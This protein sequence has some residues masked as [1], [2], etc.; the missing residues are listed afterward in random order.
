MT[1]G[2]TS[3]TFVLSVFGLDQIPGDRKP[4]IAFAGRSNVGKSSLLNKLVGRKKKMAKVSSTPGKTRSL[5][6]FL[7]NEK[8]YFVDLPGYGYA[9][10]SKKVKREWSILV[11]DYLH[12]SQDLVGLVLLLDC[13][14]DPTPED[15]QLIEWLSY[16]ELPVLI[17]LTKADKISKDKLGRK[18][19]QIASQLG[20]PVIPHST[21]S[22]IGRRE[23][24]GAIDQLFSEHKSRGRAE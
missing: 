14:R 5:N 23:L 11:E 8:H 2:V 17:A 3:C 19:R 13:R 7:I 4:Q 21:L 16:R 24:Y 20:L 6:F 12:S 9:K 15:T 22:G 10:V 1:V 18:T